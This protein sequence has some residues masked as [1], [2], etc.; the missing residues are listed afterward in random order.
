[1][2]ATNTTISTSWKYKLS[3]WRHSVDQWEVTAVAADT[4]DTKAE[5]LEN[6]MEDKAVSCVGLIQDQP[7]YEDDGSVGCHCILELHYR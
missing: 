3:P 7:K 6:T 1:M 2:S 5:L 4:K